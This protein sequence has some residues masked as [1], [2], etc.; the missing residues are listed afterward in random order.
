M[1]VFK[2][3]S[4][5]GWAALLAA[6]AQGGS[7]APASQPVAAPSAS[8]ARPFAT[9]VVTSPTGLP[10]CASLSADPDGDGQGRENGKACA[11]RSAFDITREMGV[12]W[13]LGNTMDAHGDTANPMADETRWGNPRTTKA[14]ID[15]LKQTGFNTLRLPVSWDD[16]MSGP[17]YAIDPAWMN[18]VEEIARYALDNGMVVI[19]NIHHNNGW[20]APTLAN[21]ARART[22]LTRLWTQIARRFQPY[23]HR[24][25]FE[26][27]NEPRVSVDGKDDWVGQDE[28]YQVINRL[29]AAALAAIR[30]TGG[31]NARR[32]VMLP[33]Y[34]AAAADRQLDPVVLPNDPMVALST[35]AYSPYD[36]ALNQK[37]TAVFTGGERELDALF[38]RLQRKFIQK[39]VPVVMG[40]WASTHKNNLPERTR[41]ASY[42]VRAAARAGIP[43]VVWDNGSFST[44]PQAN[45]V[46]GL[47]DR[48]NNTWVYPEL[49]DAILCAAQ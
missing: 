48:R 2:M 3:L 37:G 13:N 43:T 29:N 22:V 36:F 18:R 32:L 8:C 1:F 10:F 6:C 33:T 27:M 49:I 39:G 21:E 30:A 41:H 16:H 15:K 38:E 34:A 45:D 11:M 12:G 40:E 26:A 47:L 28:H 46:M 35:H 24:L 20:E 9:P 7:L 25:V 23:G 31:N 17:D 14:M 4:R 44:S 19:L 42:F 5:L